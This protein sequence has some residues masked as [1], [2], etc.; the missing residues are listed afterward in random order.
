M[1]IT[2]TLE[3]V[4]VYLQT[5][6][7]KYRF[8]KARLARADAVELQTELAKCRGKLAICKNDFNRTIKTQSRNINEGTRVG[9]DTI[10]QEQILWDA[11]IG[12]MLVQDAIF[13][14]KTINSYDSVSHAYDMLDTAM[15]QIA[16]KKSASRIAK[17]GTAKERNAYGYI[18][19][20]T[21]LQEK[22]ELLNG[23]FE[24]LKLTGNIDE[25]LEAVRNPSARQADLRHA[26][27]TGNTSE[28]ELG[29]DAPLTDMDEM[30][31]RLNGVEN[32]NAMTEDFSAGIDTMQ[33][34][35]PP[36]DAL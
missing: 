19:S 33:D 13:A 22:E 28:L 17:P 18:T 9:A 4:K 1:A 20:S 23:F 30:M 25:C 24:R 12:Y 7:K 31:S 36:K 14:L 29:Q 3:E 15:K 11:A 32:S 26:Y 2:D 27:T 16:G 8:R 5:L 10:I 21:A 34:I 35:H 6:K